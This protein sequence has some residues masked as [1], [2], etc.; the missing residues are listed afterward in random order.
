MEGF[1]VK[2]QD[3]FEPDWRYVAKDGFCYELRNARVFKTETEAHLVRTAL[4]FDHGVR[5]HV[6]RV[7]V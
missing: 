4:C 2:V 3:G 6:N 5:A 7:F 1:V